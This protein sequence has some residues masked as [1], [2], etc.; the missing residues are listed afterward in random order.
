MSFCRLTRI[1][2]HIEQR[3]AIEATLVRGRNIETGEMATVRI[4]PEGVGQ[5]SEPWLQVM[6]P[7]FDVTP[8]ELISKSH[9]IYRGPTLMVRLRGH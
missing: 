6:N 4:T 2:I 7:S 3:P 9:Q 5:G 1:R 8:P